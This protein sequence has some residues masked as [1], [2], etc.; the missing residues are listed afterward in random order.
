VVGQ[1]FRRG[2]VYLDG[3]FELQ[4]PSE[5]IYWNFTLDL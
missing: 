2:I 4:S 5:M 1:V 3:G